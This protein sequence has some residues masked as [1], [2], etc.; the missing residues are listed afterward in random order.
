[1]LLRR[2]P[3]GARPYLVTP[4]GGVEEG[5]TV[6]AALVG[7]CREELGAEVAPG[8]V[9]LDLPAADGHGRQTVLLAR[10]L[11]RDPEAA[12]GD[13]L[14]E[15]PGAAAR[16]SPCT[17]TTTRRWASLVARRV[18]MT[19]ATWDRQPLR[20]Q[21][22]V[23]GRTKATGAPLSGGDEFS[24]PDFAW[25]GRGDQPLV[26]TDAHVRLVHPDQNRG[27]QMLR[28]GHDV[29]DGSNGLGWM[30]AGHRRRSR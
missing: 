13:E 10:L 3:P 11:A 24:R 28:R 23:I 14:R 18:T 2:T 21:E 19:I 6:V 12:D 27:A 9:G 8:P 16:W 4:G 1:M 20:E 25:K 22:R 5:E 30:D 29:V 7:E 26:A 15:R 17:R